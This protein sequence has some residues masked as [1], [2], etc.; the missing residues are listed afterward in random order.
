MLPPPQPVETD[1]AAREVEALARM[2]A[3]ESS[4]PKAQII[5][6]WITVQAART[7][8]NIYKLVSGAEENTSKRRRN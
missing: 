6:G 3:S 2:L 4:N 1:P 8:V 5:V 7:W